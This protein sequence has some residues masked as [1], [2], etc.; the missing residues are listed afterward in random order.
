MAVQ[1]QSVGVHVPCI[2]PS[3]PACRPAGREL[4]TRLA[5]G[6]ARLIS[7]SDSY[8]AYSSLQMVLLTNS[9]CL[10]VENRLYET[11]PFD[12]A[13]FWSAIS[14]FEYTRIY[15]DSVQFVD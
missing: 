4:K 13:E 7:D 10:A 1:L 12:T 2:D 14:H 8:E 6:R 3:L 15:D 11:S 9:A 5:H